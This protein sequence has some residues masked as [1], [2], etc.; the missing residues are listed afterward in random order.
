MK[1]KE[2][3]FCV[4]AAL[5]LKYIQTDRIPIHETKEMKEKQ[6]MEIVNKLQSAHSRFKNFYEPNL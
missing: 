5:S 4:Y 2:A 3:T 6:E 1:I